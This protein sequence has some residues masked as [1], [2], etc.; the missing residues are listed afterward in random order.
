M[1]LI[2]DGNGLAFRACAQ[3]IKQPL[4]NARGENVTGLYKI[5][6]MT[7]DILGWFDDIEEVTF[8]WDG[9]GSAAKTA[10]Y[11]TYKAQRINTDYVQAARKQLPIIQNALIHFGVKQL[12]FEHIEADDAIGILATALGYNNQEVV[13][14]SSDKDMLQLVTPTCSIYSHAK[15]KMIT[16]SNFAKVTGIPSPKLVV[17]YLSILGDEGDNIIGINGIGEVFGKKI[18]K[19]FGTMENVKKAEEQIR[20]AINVKSVDS[21]LAKK[22]L[23]LLSTDNSELIHLNRSLIKLG[24]LLPLEEKAMILREYVSQKPKFDREAVL[25]IFEH[26]QLVEYARQI[27][28]IENCFKNIQLAKTF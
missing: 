25:K 23:S 27:V 6:A 17:E 16:Y 22:A 28:E 1:R 3:I 21:Q 24:A 11:P 10:I 14:I 4:T 20:L 9:S 2:I 13:V 12:R 7:K 8:I 26:Y 5:I 15:Q 18:I 19:K